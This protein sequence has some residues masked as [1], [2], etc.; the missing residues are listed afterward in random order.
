MLNYAL[1]PRIL[2][3]L[4]WAWTCYFQKFYFS[5]PA[6]VGMTSDRGWLS[7]EVLASPMAMHLDNHLAMRISALMVTVVPTHQTHT[8]SHTHTHTHICI[9]IYFLSAKHTAV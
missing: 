1:F 3:C 8:H 4:V 9:Y 6:Q 5:S 2:Q 7:A